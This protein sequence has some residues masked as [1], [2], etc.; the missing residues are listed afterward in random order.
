MPVGKIFAI[1][2]SRAAE[3]KPLEELARKKHRGVK[4]LGDRLVPLLVRLGVRRPE[5]IESESS[6]VPTDLSCCL[7]H[8][9]N[10]VVPEVIGGA[11]L[12]PTDPWKKR[13][14]LSAVLTPDETVWCF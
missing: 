14:A 3:A 11:C 1:D 10:I 2:P 7:R 6:G 8:T 13:D 12:H 4:P 5:E 9:D